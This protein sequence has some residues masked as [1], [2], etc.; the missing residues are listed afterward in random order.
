MP[1]FGVLEV[2]EYTP[3]DKGGQ[4]GGAVMQVTSERDVFD[5]LSRWERVRVRAYC[6]TIETKF[7]FSARE[8]QPYER[9]NKCSVICPL[10]FAPSPGP[11]PKGEREEEASGC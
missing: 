6:R 2:D 11:S 8:A 3:K 5:S 1:F 10:S 9:K 7:P 4:S